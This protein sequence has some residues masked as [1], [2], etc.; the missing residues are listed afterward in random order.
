MCLVCLINAE[1]RRARDGSS[2]TSLLTIDSVDDDDEEDQHAIHYFAIGSM[3]NT[4]SLALRELS[5]ISSKPAILKNHKLVFRGSGG[6]ATSEEVDKYEPHENDHDSS[7]FASEV[8]GVL[9]LLTRKN[10]ALLDQFEGGYK[11]KFCTVELYDGTQVKGGLR[12][13][14]TVHGR[15]LRCIALHWLHYCNGLHCIISLHFIAFHCISLHFVC[16]YRPGLAC[17]ALVT[18][19]WS[20]NQGRKV[21]RVLVLFSSSSNQSMVSREDEFEPSLARR[22]SALIKQTRHI[23]KQLACER[24]TSGLDDRFTRWRC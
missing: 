15:W 12:M 24:C 4:V 16:S 18:P 22:S 8:H 6:M 23:A 17:E 5:P 7:E 20:W 11:R 19:C 10:M 14:W 1:E 2:S 9:H 21:N 13:Q 3:T